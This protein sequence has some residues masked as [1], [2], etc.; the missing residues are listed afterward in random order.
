M[1]AGINPKAKGQLDRTE[2][3]SDILGPENVFGHDHP[4]RQHTRRTRRRSTLA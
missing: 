3:T 1:V 2:T 4:R